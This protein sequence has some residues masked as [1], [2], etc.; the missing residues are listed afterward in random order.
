VSSCLPQFNT[1]KVFTLYLYQNG[2]ES[3][4]GNGSPTVVLTFQYFVKPNIQTPQEYNKDDW[5]YQLFHLTKKNNQVEK[6]KKARV[7]TST[8]CTKPPKLQAEGYGRHT[9]K[10]KQ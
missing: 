9:Q 6:K 7:P 2:L 10:L 3:S 5:G 1:K 8:R 4:D